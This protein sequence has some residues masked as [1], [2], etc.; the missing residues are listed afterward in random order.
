MVVSITFFIFALIIGVAVIGRVPATL[1][2]PLMSGA[3]SIHGVVLVGVIVVAAGSNSMLGNIVIFFAALLG[4]LNVVGGYV[5]TDR[6]LEM[7]K[8]KREVSELEEQLGEELSV[9]GGLDV[10]INDVVINEAQTGITTPSTEALDEEYAQ[11]QAVIASKSEKAVDAGSDAV[12]PV[13][14]QESSPEPAI[15]EA[16]KAPAESSAPVAKV[17]VDKPDAPKASGNKGAKRVPSVVKGGAVKATKTPA[18]KSPV[19]NDAK[20]DA[21]TDAKTD[22]KPAV[23]R[24]TKSGGAKDTP[25]ASKKTPAKTTSKATAQEK[26][27]D[28]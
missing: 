19:K 2:T 3:N 9:D 24:A 11:M 16:L 8:P 15:L 28:K 6:M 5:V 26:D 22:A 17:A 1:H 13:A 20:N 12:A 4:T 14:D 7:F 21:K 18:K 23:K 27:G 25:S 10:M